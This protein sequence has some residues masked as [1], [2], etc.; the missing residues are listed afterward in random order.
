[1]DKYNTQYKMIISPYTGDIWLDRNLGASRICVNYKDKNCYG[2]YF[3][4]GR[5]S[6]GHEK[7]NSETTSGIS[8]SSIPNH[9]QFIKAA[10]IEKKEGMFASRGDWIEK[11]SD[12]LWQGLDGENN[13][14]P[15]SF[16][17]PTIDELLVETIEKN[18]IGMKAMYNNF[19][20]LPATGIR[21]YRDARIGGWNGVWSSSTGA[22]PLS[23]LDLIWRGSYHSSYE[24][25]YA[26]TWNSLLTDVVK[27]D[28][29][30]KSLTQKSDMER[31]YGIPIRCIKN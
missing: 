3:Q 5:D 26:L 28:M 27:Y 2:D 10:Y 13:P 9:S 7:K 14:C 23:L 22:N 25:S 20:K 8:S 12:Y 11:Q 6:D 4:W 16:R 15:K 19:L 18:T 30:F 31:A 29:T 21:Y 1:M 24:R 17:V